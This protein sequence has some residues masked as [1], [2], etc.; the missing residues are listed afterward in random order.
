[1]GSKL[2]LAFYFFLLFSINLSCSRLP[3]IEE[4]SSKTMVPVFEVFGYARCSNCPN[5]ERALDSLK[6]IYGDSVIVLEY[7]M[8]VLGDTLSPISIL[9]RQGL[10]NIG[11]SAPV[12]IVQGTQRIE[13]ATGVSLSLFENY[14]NSIR[15]FDDSVGLYFEHQW[16]GDSLLININIENALDFSGARLFL[17]LTQDSVFF[18]Q[19]GAPDSIFNNVVRHYES[20]EATFPKAWSAHRFLVSGKTLVILLQDT[21]NLKIFS[22]TQRRF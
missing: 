7:H 3:Q 12:T 8:R 14:Y 10:Y 19:S 1:M 21:V 9:E 18:K 20:F 22:A 11:T 2:W 13:G 15:R 17:F 5:V 4:P 6:H 16:L